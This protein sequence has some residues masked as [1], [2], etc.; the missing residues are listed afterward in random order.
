M[1]VQISGNDITVPRDGTFSRNVSIAGTLTYE[2]VTNVDSIGLVTARNGIEVGASPGVAA[3]ISVD[4]NMI[5]SGISTFGGDVQ[6]PDKIIHSGDTN[7]AIRFP[8]NDTVS[9]ETGGSEAARFDSSGRLLVGH[10]ASVG[11]DRQVQVV[12]NTADESS[13]EIIRHIADA[14]APKI[15]FSKSRNATKGSSTIVQDNDSLGEIHFRGD[16]GTDLLTPAATI[17]GVVDG[18][19][20]S[21]DMPGAL[22]FRTTADGAASTTERLRISKDGSIGIAGE[23]YGTSGQVLTSGGASAA[24]TW[25]AAGGISMIDTWRITQG[26][27]NGANATIGYWASAT[28]KLNSN[29][30]TG[31]TYTS[32]VFSFPSTGHY[33]MTFNCRFH[34]SSGNDGTMSVFLQ[35][36]TDNGTYEDAALTSYGAQEGDTKATGTITYAFDITDT[37]NQKFR[38]LTDS[39]GSSSEVM[40]VSTENQTYFQ[41]IRLA[42]T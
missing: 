34:C 13:I 24:P 17:V 36:T 30:G 18:T 37:S 7:T 6:V 15:D 4:G 16:D 12:G 39:F 25:A 19:P 31:L 11:S 23:N 14:N 32:H 42:D 29:L 1:A 3:S 28:N 38:F 40:G 26:T 41:M 10:T 2:D 5:V 21:N 22:L 27:G 33:L 20:G 8:D 35:V 9:V